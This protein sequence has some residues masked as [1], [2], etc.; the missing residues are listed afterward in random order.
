ME[1]LFPGI[2]SSCLQCFTWSHNKGEGK[3]AKDV[4]NTDSRDIITNRIIKTALRAGI[5]SWTE[6]FFFFN[7]CLIMLFDIKIDYGLKMAKEPQFKFQVAPPRGLKT[8]HLIS[9][10]LVFNER[11]FPYLTALISFLFPLCFKMSRCCNSNNLL[12]LS[13]ERKDQCDKLSIHDFSTTIAIFNWY[14]IIS[15]LFMLCYNI[16]LVQ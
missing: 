9:R 12:V 10:H 5:I 7:K 6:D 2:R 15:T 11:I 13:Y 3:D 4:G 16:L 14:L 8:D 1:A